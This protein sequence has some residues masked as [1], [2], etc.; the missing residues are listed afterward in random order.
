MQGLNLQN[1][2]CGHNGRIVITVVTT[3]TNILQIVKAYMQ[4]FI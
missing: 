2:N 1:Y 3:I 4:W